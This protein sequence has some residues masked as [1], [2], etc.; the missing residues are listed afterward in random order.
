MENTINDNNKNMFKCGMVILNYLNYSETL[1]LANK[2]K[3]Y[4]CLSHIVIVDNASPNDSYAQ[5]KKIESDKIS[6]ISTQKNEGYSSGNNYGVRYL[7]ENYDIDIV[8]I[9]NPDVEFSELFVR[10]ILNDFRDRGEL[11]ILTGVQLD[12]KGNMALHP[13]WQNYTIKE[14]F[15]FKRHSLR[16]FYHLSKQTSDY[17]YAIKKIKD[18]NSI[19]TVGAV[20]GSLFFVRKDDFVKIGLFDEN[21][22][23]YHEEDIIAKKIASIGGIIAVDPSVTYVHYGAQTTSKV[24]ASSTKSKH[25]FNSSVYFFNNYMSNNRALRL[26]NLLLCWTIRTEDSFFWKIKKLFKKKKK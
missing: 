14:Y 22:A 17:R 23:F 21:I 2:I 15:R 25:L 13:F 4:K 11:T 26:I 8:A 24:F 20:E 1:L 18:N 5:L 19:F 16:L 12:S 3:D 9:S 10:T 6:I 7:I